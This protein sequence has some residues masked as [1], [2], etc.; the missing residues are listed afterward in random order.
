MKKLIVTKD[1]ALIR[2]KYSLTISE[3]RVI[4]ICIGKINPNEA[5]TQ[6]TVFEVTAAELAEY[7]G[8]ARTSAYRDLQQAIERLWGREIYFSESGKMRWVYL[9]DYQKENASAVLQFS[10]N[11]IPFLT[12]LKGRF[13]SYDIRNVAR[14]K[15]SY[16][17]RLYEILVQFPKL[18]EQKIPLMQLRDMLMLYDDETGETKYPK[19][20]QLRR[21][22]IDPALESINA[23]SNIKVSVESI[24]Q[25]KE[26]IAFLFKYQI[27]SENATKITNEFIEK[28]ARPG[29][30]WQQARERLN[31]ARREIKAAPKS[32]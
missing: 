32:Q 20:A 11:I 23:Y 25:K 19:V 21:F 3:Q 6:K 27:G 17:F 26:I 30:S 15:S 28:Y 1:N 7:S 14:F 31:K 29:E 2:A 4:L 18:T 16:A 5:I 12:E 10:P 9:V 13:T 8:A 22:V 24:K